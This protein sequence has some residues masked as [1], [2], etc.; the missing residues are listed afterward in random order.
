LR[1]RSK[2]LAD[3]RHGSLSIRFSGSGVDVVALHG[4]SLTGR[5]FER[6]AAAGT[7]TVAAPDLPGHGATTISPVDLTTTVA[8][9]GEWL[10]T[11]D[12]P[13]PVLGYS[14]G[15]RIAL[16]LAMSRPH[17]VERLILISATPGIRDEAQRA[18]R[19]AADADLAASLLADGLSAFLDRWLDHPLVGTA[20][21][22]PS[23]RVAD[24]R[25]REENSAAGLA[26]ALTGFGQGSQRWVGDRLSDLP[27]PLLAVAGARDARYTRIAGEMAAAV[28]N[29]RAVVIEDSGHNVVLEAPERLAAAVD[30]FLSAQLD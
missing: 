14:Q 19:A 20:S 22:P 27:M 11:L 26:A 25:V 8:A 9:L 18:S 1:S 13:I 29:G 2:T 30:S 23:V 15:G 24:R 12:R 10:E 5:Q 21:M 28:P 4:F 17:L 7:L 6:F 16:V 3:T